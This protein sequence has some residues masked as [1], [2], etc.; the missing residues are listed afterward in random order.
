MQA[1]YALP[2]VMLL[3]AVQVLPLFSYR[4]VEDESWYSSTAYSLFH[5]GQVRNGSFAGPD[6][7]SKADTRPLA[8]PGTLALAFAA[9]G[10]GP[11]QARIPEFLVSLAAIP[12]MFLLGKSLGGTRVGLLAALLLSVDNILFL[13]ARTV[14]PEAFVTFFGLAAVLL[15]F[16]SRRRDSVWLAAACGLALGVAL[17]YHVNGV[18]I[19]AGLGLLLA[20]EFRFSLW[21]SRRAWA[22]V[23]VSFATLV[24]YGIW[25]A[26]DPV[27]WE[28]FRVLYGR[29]S[30]LTPAAILHFEGVRYGD[31]L[32]FGSQRFHFLPFSLPLRLHI[33]LLI[34]ASLGVLAWKKRPLFWT[35]LALT[36]PSLLLWL[37]EV[38][39]TV[40]FFAILAPYGALAVALAFYALERPR[41]RILLGCWCALCVVTEIGGNLLVLQQARTAD[42]AGCTERLRALIP[43]DARVYGAITFFMALHDRP[44]YSWNRTPLDLAVGKLAVNYLVLNDRVLLH[45]SGYGKDDWQE[46]RETVNAFV[47][48]NAELVGTAPDRFY[49]DL[50]VYRVKANP[51]RED[52]GVLP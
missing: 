19:A 34:V 31:L 24:P 45:G 25:L 20:A 3:F 4:W 43:P 14:R 33:V 32:G 11:V 44:F 13:S 47:R 52:A 22:L 49:G 46:L 7:E 29:G 23:L 39:G 18:A 40:R 42:Y 38:N 2:A 12:L 28:A 36:V 1:R 41:W 35:L 9:L 51:R 6:L 16:V 26:H 50:E 5:E 30:A 48:S 17:N 27:R 37:K 21:K 10:V 15:Y 8:M